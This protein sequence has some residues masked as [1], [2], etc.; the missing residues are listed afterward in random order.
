M[1]IFSHNTAGGLFSSQ[2]D[3][4]NKN[5]DNPEADLF[6]ILDQLE[7]YRKTNGNFHLKLCYPEITGEDGGHCN[8]WVQSSNPVTETNVTGFREISLAF[9]KDGYN[10]SWA[11]L[12]RSGGKDTLIDDSRGKPP[13]W[14]SAV[15]AMKNHPEES[16]TIPGPYYYEVRRVELYVGSES[17]SA[18]TTT[19]TTTTTTTTTKSK[20]PIDQILSKMP[21]EIDNSENFALFAV[22]AICMK[23]CLLASKV[24][25]E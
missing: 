15:G 17:G 20:Q 18:S 5:P 6:S 11:G 2:K 21:A 10:S 8:S 12:G 13:N 7:S 14:M 4:L 3:A 1:K 16:D 19:S 24:V 23:I 22:L 9:T 25:G